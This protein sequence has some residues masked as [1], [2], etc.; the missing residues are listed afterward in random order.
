MTSQEIIHKHPK[1]TKD[2]GGKV[3]SDKY[4]K[5]YLVDTN[6]K[7]RIVYKPKDAM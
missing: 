1:K 4:I 3:P 7:V 2:K 6:R 5:A